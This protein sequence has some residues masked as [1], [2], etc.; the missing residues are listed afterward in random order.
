MNS[1]LCDTVPQFCRTLTRY[2][3]Q[4]ETNGLI[5]TMYMNGSICKYQDVYLYAYRTDQKPYCTN[6]RIY[7]TQTNDMYVPKGQSNFRLYVQSNKQGWRVD[8]TGT[9]NKGYRDRCEDPRLVVVKDRLYCFWTDGFKMYYGELQV[10][11]NDGTVTDIRLANQWTP[12]PPYIREL[13]NDD[14]Y[15]G[16][17]KNWTPFARG[18][19]L[20][21]VYSY[22]PFICLHLEEGKVVNMVR[23]KYT[24]E[25]KH[26]FIKGG[27]PAVWTGEC[28]V[29]FFHSTQRIDGIAYYFMG[30]CTFSEDLVPLEISRYPIVA[31]YPD[32]DIER[33]NTSYVIFPAGV[34][35]EDDKWYVS[36]GYNDHDVKVH[37]FTNRE[38]EYNLTPAIRKYRVK[39]IW[40]TSK[41]CTPMA[42]SQTQ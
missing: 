28:Y 34:V 26:G 1:V 10:H 17:E 36:F 14:K 11:I 38:L 29:T 27:T 41:D 16:R 9:C 7:I 33:P 30:A 40:S 39:N 31:P 23:S 42:G 25:W 5:H 2:G 13:Y 12:C 37:A 19:Q 15:D 18:D 24:Y 4:P 22:S 20:W 32:N 6:P 21:V 35:H 8:Y 3:L